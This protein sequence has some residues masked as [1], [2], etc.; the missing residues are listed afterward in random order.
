MTERIRLLVTMTD[1]GVV[2]EVER[3]KINEAIQKARAMLQ[4]AGQRVVPAKAVDKRSAHSLSGRILGLGPQH[5]SQ[6][7]DAAEVTKALA[8]AGYHYS[9]VRVC[10]ELLRLVKRGHLRRIGE[11][12]KSNPYHYV[13]P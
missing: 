12:T 1:V 5:F 4:E 13:N 7:K 3:A 2:V 9:L 11:G 8:L 6:P 10:D